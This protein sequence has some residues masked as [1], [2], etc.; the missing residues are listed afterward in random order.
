MDLGGASW[1]WAHGQ[2]FTV[3]E[4][5]ENRVGSMEGALVLCSFPTLVSQ[6]H[7]CKH[8]AAIF[9]SIHS[10]ALIFSLSLSRS[11]VVLFTNWEQMR[12]SL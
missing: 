4:E 2:C 1:D 11:I 10:L 9:F 6:W 8:G 7:T 5:E 3:N 12:L